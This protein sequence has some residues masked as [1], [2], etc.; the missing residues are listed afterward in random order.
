MLQLFQIVILIFSAII[1]E[2][3]H[4]WMADRLGDPTARE[5]GRLTLNPI[6]HIDLFGSILLPALFIFSGANF[7][8]GWAKPVPFNPYNLRDQKYGPAKV[9]IAGPLGNLIIALIFGLAL[10]FFSPAILAYGVNMVYIFIAIVKI[11]L[12]LMVFN[13]IPIPPMDGSKVLSPF[14]PAS[15]RNKLWELEHYGMIFVLIFVMLGF[16]VIVEPIVNFLLKLIIG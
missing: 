10:R 16:S 6:A 14:L 15:W 1:H 7:I 9:A 4:G 11:N 13:L 5:E 3:M 2:Y 8:L 12:L